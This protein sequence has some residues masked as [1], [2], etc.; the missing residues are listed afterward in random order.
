MTSLAERLLHAMNQK[1]YT[2]KQL[3]K[4]A[5]TS[6]VTIS[7]IL[8]GETL[9]PRN[10]VE[11][12]DALNVNTKW[13]QTGYGEETTDT[14]DKNEDSIVIDVLNVE[15]SAG[16]GSNGDL[17]EV[18][19]QLHYVPKQFYT[20]FRGI[21]PSNI[22]VINIKGDSMYPTFSTGD[23]IFVDIKVNYFDGD[24]IYVFTYKNNIYVKRLQLAGEML[25]VLSDN[26]TYK[27]WEITEENLEELHIQGKVKIHQSQQLNFI[28]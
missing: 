28:G 22:R 2:Q 11:I 24:G 14:L 8:R 16:N 12:A 6:Q 23:M 15:A 4:K 5:K 1:G 26:P 9:K 21:N 20:Y 7:N 13:L 10:L 25:L 3:A 17:V 27:Q 19:S 18:V